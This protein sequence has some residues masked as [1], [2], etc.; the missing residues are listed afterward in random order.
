M[1]LFIY[2]VKNCYLV[3]FFIYMYTVKIY[4]Y[5]QTIISVVYVRAEQGNIK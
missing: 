2:N 3:F 4:T 5:N 1:I